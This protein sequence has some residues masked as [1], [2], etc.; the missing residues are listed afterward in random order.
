M[1]LAQGQLSKLHSLVEKYRDISSVSLT[2]D[3]RENVKPYKVHLKSDVILIKHV[4][5]LQKNGFIR[6]NPSRRWSSPVLIV[7]KPGERDEFRM[8]V[9]CRYAN[10]QV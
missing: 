10:S 5:M 4:K 2:D 7:P 3:G 1:Y 8:T 6:K 9:D